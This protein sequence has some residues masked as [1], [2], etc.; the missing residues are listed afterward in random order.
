MLTALALLTPDAAACGGFFCNNIDPVEQKGETIVFEVDRQANETTMHVQVEYQGPPTEFAWVIPVR[1]EPDLKLSN[2]ALFSQLDSRTRPEFQLDTYAEDAS[3]QWYWWGDD[4]ALNAN[5]GGPPSNGS[6]D[7]LQAGQ[8]GPYD[9][10]VLAADDT[11][12]LLL[13]LQENGYAVPNSMGTAIA[14]YLADGHNFVA[15]RLSS[16]QTTGDL[17]PLALTYEG[18]TPAIPL[19]LTGIAAVDDMRL[20]T[21]VLADTRAVPDN[22][23]HVKINHAA[24]RWFDAAWW[25]PGG[26]GYDEVVTR[27]ADEAGGHAFATD[28]AGATEPLQGSFYPEGVSVSDYVQPSAEAFLAQATNGVVPPSRDMLNALQQIVP[29][30]EGTDARSV[31]NCPSCY[32]AELATWHADWDGAAA[33]AAFDAAIL[34]PL[35]DIEAMFERQPHIT[36]LSSSVS[37]AEMNLDPMFTLNADIPQDQPRLHTAQL[38]QECMDEGDQWMDMTATLVLPDGKA[39]ELPSH[40]T[41]QE[42][43]VYSWSDYLAMLDEPAAETIEDMGASGPP[44][45]LY[46]GSGD[47]RSIIDEMNEDTER[48]ERAR[49]GCSTVGGSGLAGLVVLPFVFVL[50]RRR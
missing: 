47:I 44:R 36:R 19:Q 14:P 29:V 5:A 41:M 35:R 2:D 32:S 25:N 11:E 46:D 10:V 6:V 7:V 43:G 18:M 28:F 13:W 48:H 38:L 20:V 42:L 39:I 12:A 40:N 17:E 33:A 45:V 4:F 26:A 8:V 16:G 27:A 21:Y 49:R 30:P 22:Y 24:I 15:L 31:Y 23:L 50:G 1:G 3:C 34:S 37:P 9:T